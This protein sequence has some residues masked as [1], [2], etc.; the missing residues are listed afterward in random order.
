MG[1]L[2]DSEMPLGSARLLSLSFAVW[3]PLTTV[4]GHA[5]QVK[6]IFLRL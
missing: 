3:W 2:K 1:L 5:H 4:M 6:S